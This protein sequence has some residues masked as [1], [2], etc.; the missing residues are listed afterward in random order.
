MASQQPL[1]L[2][3]SEHSNV[4][5]GSTAAQRRN[6]PGSFSLEAEMPKG[7]ESEFAKR[8]S[9]LHACMELLITADPE[10]IEAAEPL[11]QELI[12]QDMGF[13]DE[14]QVTQELVDTKLRPALAAWFEIVAEYGI[15]DWFI[16][17]RVSLE[18]VVPGAFGT[19]DI[20]AKD[21]SNRL[22]SLD[23]KFGDGVPVPVEANDGSAFYT[24]AAMY[25]ADPELNEFCADIEG[26]IF[27]I[28]Q[29][30]VGSNRV[31][32]SWETDEAWLEAWL[33]Q[34][35]AAVDRARQ[36]EPPVK[37]GPW[38]KWCAAKPICP[39]HDQLASEA[40][41]KAPE[42]MTAVELADA[43]QKAE[44]LKQWISDVYKLA[45][46][47]LEGGAAV[48]GYKLVQKMPRRQWRDEAEAEKAL[49][50]AK[51]KV[52]DIFTKKIITPTALQKLNEAVY[53]KLADDLVIL[54]SSGLTVAPDSDRREAVT[55]SME[56]L[57]NALPDSG[58]SNS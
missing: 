30:R 41:G 11:M 7:P 56:L 26:I 18:A 37:A 12:G 55:S 2:G 33:D 27:H 31:Y 43:L 5:G 36:P 28:V 42:S 16:E 13:G 8:G 22:H 21:T 45:Q 4:M 50:R 14:F 49:R 46:R 24:A 3:V 53:S 1:P 29:P 6:C 25:D 54:H 47:E 48:P 10:N 58:N 9:M 35:A 15:D 38:C 20:L 52:A 44:L 51:V 34:T 32:E 39:A 23:W 57:A 17:Q 40:L 19:A